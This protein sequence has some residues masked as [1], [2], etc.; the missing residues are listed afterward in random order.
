MMITCF[1]RTH[2]SYVYITLCQVGDEIA[3]AAAKSAKAKKKAEAAT[4]KKR[5][6]N[7]TYEEV[8][9]SEDE[10]HT[11]LALGRTRKSSRAENLEQ[12]VADST[13]R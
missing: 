10:E 11:M 7:W 8:S 5:K 2:T 1:P 6:A 3:A 13:I 9:S 4:T 12:Q